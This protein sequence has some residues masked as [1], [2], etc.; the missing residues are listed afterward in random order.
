MGL[1][2]RKARMKREFHYS[3]KISFD[4]HGLTQNKEEKKGCL[5]T[6]LDL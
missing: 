2:G 5:E 3:L 1:K 6:S 4:F